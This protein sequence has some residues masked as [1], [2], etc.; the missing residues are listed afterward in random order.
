MGYFAALKL[1]QAGLVVLVARNIQKL[2]KVKVDIEKLGGQAIC[3]VCDFS[4]L[5]SVNK[6][7]REIIDL[8]LTLLGL[9]NNAGIMTNS[10][11]KSAQGLDL[12]FATNHLGPF[13]FTELLLPHLEKN[14]NILFTC[15]TSENPESGA[16]TAGF[17]GSRFLSVEQ[18]ARGEYK[19]NG[20][21]VKGFDAYATSKQCNLA[22]VLYFA[23]QY[24][25]F[26][27]NALEPGFNPG[28]ALGKTSANLLTEFV[29]LHLMAP[30]SPL[31]K[32]WST[33]KSAGNVIAKLV[34]TCEATGVYYNEKARSIQGSKE[35]QN[36]EFCKQIVLDTRQFISDLGF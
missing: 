11:A 12:T 26:K 3:V 34:T 17:R 30:L 7:S 23:S 22:T 15:S 5:E 36:I 10:D 14:S 33:P 25:D 27:I 6:A 13:L 35:V 31:I 8:D 28:T 20:S 21:K 29:M 24:K 4:D 2:E 19:A 18:S 32:G 9:A 1:A 16:K